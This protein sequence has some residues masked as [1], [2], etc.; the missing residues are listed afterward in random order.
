MESGGEPPLRGH[1]FISYVHED[2]PRVDHL[3]KFL[4]ENGIPVWRDTEDLAPGE[5]WETTIRNAIAADSLVFIACFSRH[6]EQKQ[7]SYQW[8]EIRLAID[9]LR[10][11]PPGRRYLLPVRFDA[12]PVPDLDIGANR[13]LNSLQR[14]DL[15]GR[16]RKQN[17]ERLA[18][19]IQDIFRQVEGGEAG[20]GN[21]QARS[22]RGGLALWLSRP[23]RLAVIL[24]S[25][26]VVMAATAAGL[27]LSRTGPA[28]PPG[29]RVTDNTGAVSVI[30]P[31]SWGDVLGNGWHPHVQGLFNGTLIG[32]GLNAAPNIGAWF[33]DL[34]TPG[35]FVGA[36]KLLINDH[37]TPETIL[38]VMASPCDFASRQPVTADR[39]TGYQEMWTCPHSATRFE[40]V[41]LWPGNHSFIA[42]IELKIVTPV[43]EASGKRAL[44]SLI[45]H[46]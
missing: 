44:A 41:A 26:A 29:V 22:R 19:S 34:T 2:K 14:A 5:D 16:N 27:L 8:G 1:V 20:A 13:T 6:S 18:R 38:S 45:V 39:L 37:Y 42:F 24:A 3:H 12:C 32:P 36:S 28:L 4:E 46:Y 23:W 30:V 17:T 15:F 11:R 25:A 21:E 40:T 35:I 7:K 9:Q 10:L 33:D 31:K 43:D